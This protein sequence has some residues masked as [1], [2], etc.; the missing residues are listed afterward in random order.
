MVSASGADDR[1]SA[2]SSPSR[3]PRPAARRK[4]WGWGLEGEGLAVSEIE[5]LG[6]TYA[7][8]LGARL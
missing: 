8:A 1:V 5:Q 2:A 3:M 6:A 4:F 7:C